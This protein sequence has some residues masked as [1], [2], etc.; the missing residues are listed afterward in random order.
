MASSILNNSLLNQFKEMKN[1]NL[2]DRLIRVFLSSTFRD[3]QAERDELVKLFKRLEIE[4]ARRNVTVQLV[5]LR[6]GITDDA[7]RNGR[8]IL[9]C[10]Q[11]IDNSHPFFIGLIGDRYGY[12]PGKEEIERC[13]DILKRFPAISQYIDDHLSITEIEMRHGALEAAGKVDAAFFLKEGASTECPAHETLR[14]KLLN[15]QFQVETYNSIKQLSIKVENTFK[16][17]LNKY[18]P[19]KPLSQLDLDRLFQQSIL[20]QKCNLYIP[21]SHNFDI[22]NNWL[23][24]EH[25]NHFAIIGSSGLGKSALIANW[26]DGLQTDHNLIYHFIGLSDTTPDTILRR[27]INEIRE[28]YH[29]SCEKTEKHYKIIEE[30]NYLIKQIV[31]DKPLLIV[32]DGLNQLSASDNAKQLTWL[33]QFSKNIKILVSTVPDDETASVLKARNFKEF[34]IEPIK[35]ETRHELIRLYLSKAGK[36]LN[37][38]QVNRIANDNE[39]S[40]PLVLRSLLDELIIYGS[41]ESLDTMI[42]YYLSSQTISEFFD[43]VLSKAENFYGAEFVKRALSVIAVSKDGLS[44]SELL[45][46]LKCNPLE[47]SE[48]YCGYAAH[49]SR[50][51]GLIS[52]SH[53][54]LLEAVRTRYLYDTESSFE[55]ELRQSIVSCISKIPERHRSYTELAFQYHALRD[56][57]HLHNLLL[58][59]PVFLYFKNEAPSTLTQYWRT[60]LSE[61]SY[62]LEDYLNKDYYLDYIGLYILEYFGYHKIALTFF[63]KALTLNIKK[64]NND[65][66]VSYNNIGLVYYNLDDFD[67]ALIY[68]NKALEVQLRLHEEA[69]AITATIYNNIGGAYDS[70][71]IYEKALMYYQKALDIR[72]KVLGENDEDTATSYNNLG[73]LYDSKNEFSKALEYHLKALQIR[74]AVRRK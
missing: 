48:L 23:L 21:E 65:T 7:A 4:A 17:F 22:L 8:V 47:W 20:R 16:K 42:D 33:Q 12:C 36:E 72:L 49:F 56:F 30:F 73:Y 62:S 35:I 3:M 71:S 46:I 39:S 34:K 32:L 63:D 15:S 50:H 41:H 37:E 29:I 18:F 26:L 74:L 69:S 6:W 9:T 14:K 10:L 40:N 66:A 57:P 28:I 1:N 45:D 67:K 52:F 60:L 43:R 2:E 55:K 54:Y 64:D 31:N 44:E 58:H 19:N 11:E 70:I 27:L 53:Q 59:M 38:N 68:F 13:T 51:G 61:S 5:D 25:E 24:S